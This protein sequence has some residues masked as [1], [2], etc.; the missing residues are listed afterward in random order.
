MAV[1]AYSPVESDHPG[2]Y[3]IPGYTKYG[4]SADGRIL[5]LRTGH[6]KAFYQ[7]RSY[8]ATTVMC[9][10]K[11]VMV[12]MFQHRLVALAFHGPMPEDRPLVNHKDGVKTNRHPT[13]LEWISYSGNSH[14]AYRTGLRTDNRPV[15]AKDLLTDEITRFYCLTECAR[16]FGVNAERIWR[17]L[18][19]NTGNIYFGS[20]VFRY[21]DDP[22]PWPELTADDVGKTNNGES[23]PV[24]AKRLSDGAL[25]RTDSIGQMA[26]LTGVKFATV[27]YALRTGKQ[28]NCFGYL[29]KYMSDVRPWIS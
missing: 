16:H 3:I 8:P 7:L 21:E 26:E 28:Y 13:N 9:D 15:L 14:H 24:R 5:N 19:D 18:R 17:N 11:N 29:F 23:K 27:A 20:H 12:H 2:F 4:A 6:E 10:V 25:F 1:V 22:R